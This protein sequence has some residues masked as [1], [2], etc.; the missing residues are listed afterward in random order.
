MDVEYRDLYDVYKFFLESCFFIVRGL[1]FK[2][3]MVLRDVDRCVLKS[4]FVF[5]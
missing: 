1:F 5:R 4:F 2:C 3:F